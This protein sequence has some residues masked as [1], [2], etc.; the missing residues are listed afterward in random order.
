M[1]IGAGVWARYFLYWPET[2]RRGGSEAKLG[3]G[4]H[5]RKGTAT[6]S[7]IPNIHLLPCDPLPF[8]KTPSHHHW[9]E[10]WRLLDHR[11][12]R[13]METDSN[14][15]IKTDRNEDIRKQAVSLKAESN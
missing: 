14:T 3:V 11:P 9:R 6:S 7:P 4:E 13:E 5:I 10:K 1:C 2:T 15:D 8:S 12:P